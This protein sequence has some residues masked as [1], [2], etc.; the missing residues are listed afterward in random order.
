MNKIQKVII[1]LGVIA[2]LALVLFP[3]YAAM[4]LPREENVHG[5]IG[6]H[7]IWKPPTAEYAYEVLI[8]EEYDSVD[9]MDL[10]SFLVIFN[11]VLF[12][13]NFIV[14]FLISFV[15]LIVFRKRGQK[16]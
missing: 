9:G 5:F 10:S 15:L 4:K 13:F 11:K 1:L 6:Y 2:F 14:L 8:G 12:I 16:I 7:P 3:P